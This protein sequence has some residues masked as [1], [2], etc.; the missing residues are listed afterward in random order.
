MM[1]RSGSKL[2]RQLGIWVYLQFTFKR[3]G[4][5]LYGIL[6]QLTM[7]L[8][9]FIFQLLQSD[10]LNHIREINTKCKTYNIVKCFSYSYLHDLANIP[11]WMPYGC[12][13]ST[14]V[15]TCAR[16]L[17]ITLHTNVLNEF[18]KIGANKIFPQVNICFFK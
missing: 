18:Q 14:K 15:L 2:H 3:H 9:D 8:D 17:H 5:K 13:C 1:Y 4:A 12:I 11:K 10:W 6:R 7:I 16:I